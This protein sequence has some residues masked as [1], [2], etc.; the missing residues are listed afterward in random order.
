MKQ[1]YSF[2][3]ISKT[4]NIILG[5]ATIW[6]MFFHSPT[7]YI[8]NIFNNKIIQAIIIFIRNAKVK[9]EQVIV[10]TMQITD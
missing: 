10:N 9:K 1:S 7:L 2:S 3:N 6:I 5:I 8:E 4:R